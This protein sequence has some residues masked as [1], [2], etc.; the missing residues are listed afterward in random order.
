M[1]PAH[2]GLLLLGPPLAR[3]SVE[4]LFA[5]LDGLRV[6]SRWVTG[7]RVASRSR[8]VAAVARHLKELRPEVVLVVE[9]NPGTPTLE[10]VRAA[11][12]WSDR[13]QGPVEPRGPAAYFAPVSPGA[14]VT[15]MAEAG[16]PARVTHTSGGSPGNA[17]FYAV[18]H[19]LA[20]SGG[21]GP[22]AFIRL[23]LLPEA[24]PPGEALPSMAWE[25]QLTGVRAAITGLE[26]GATGTRSR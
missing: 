9:V 20:G 21:G 22:A 4:R 8:P 3:D 6:G 10:V 16:V 1:E 13:L 19:L 26:G 11:L 24:V 17:L 23:P 5:S 15:C 7:R 14:L 25:T 18:L 12:N 2:P